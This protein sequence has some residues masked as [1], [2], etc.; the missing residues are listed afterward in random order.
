[1]EVG[2]GT[3]SLTNPGTHLLDIDAC[4]GLPENC[5]E[6]TLP[7][8]V[9]LTGWVA[10]HNRSLLSDDVTSDSRYVR[11][12]DGLRSVM[13]VPLRYESTT[14][15]VLS[16]ES[17]KPHRFSPENLDELEVVADALVRVLN[18]IWRVVNL[19]TKSK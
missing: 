13:A 19:K 15:G 18:R 7:M 11:I 1:F 9:G 14:L 5:R 4:V 16:L 6:W 10:L 8:C 17:R 3:I 2:Y 12:V